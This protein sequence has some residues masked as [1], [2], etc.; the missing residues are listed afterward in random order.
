MVG[1]TLRGTVFWGID[2]LK[3]KTVKQ[4]YN[5]IKQLMDSNAPNTKQL[6]SICNHAYNTVPFYT[7]L[8][9]KDFSELPVITKTQYKEMYASFQSQKYLDNVYHQMSTSGSTGTPFTVNQDKVKRERTMAEVIYFN[10]IEG[11]TLG[12]K[13]MHFKAWSE[14]KSTIER[15][16]Q[17]LVPIDILRLDEEALESIRGLLKTDKQINSCLAYASSYE[18]LCNYLFD[19]G[20]TPNMFHLNVIFSSSSLLKEE[21]R[22]K[23]EKI[24]DC[25]IIDRYANQ[26]NGILA[27]TKS[28]SRIFNV[29]RASYYIE[30]L[31]LDSDE[32][33]EAGE[34]GRLIVTDLYNYAMPI[35]RYDTGDL[36]I[37]DDLDRQNIS[38]LRSIQ[39]RLVDIIYDT[40]GNILTP[41]TI[42]VHMKKYGRL[43]QWQF[44][45]EDKNEYVLRV[46]GAEGI[47]NENDFVNSLKTILGED[48][49]IEVKFVNEIP[50]LSSGKF[51]N[52]ICNYKIPQGK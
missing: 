51:K 28:N 45:Q 27:Q 46:N 22:E 10:E 31:K 7:P 18:V 16:K 35:I 32:P 42:S 11:Q 14:K 44:I 12:Q 33:A 1:K 36:A 17:N 24:F 9:L 13:Y 6:Q 5:D 3:G 37:S 48:A 21:T 47:Y 50:V 49:N 20:D 19:K 52:T 30:L 34:L 2:A 8:K 38:T 41:H 23:L 4:H 26:E 15:L 39:G 40:Q 43:K 25:P 29:N